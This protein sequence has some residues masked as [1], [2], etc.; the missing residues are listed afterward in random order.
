MR[1]W[2]DADGRYT[3]NGYTSW[4]HKLNGSIQSLFSPSRSASQ[5][6]I[7]CLDV[8]SPPYDISIVWPTPSVKDGSLPR[9]RNL[10]IVREFSTEPLQSTVINLLNHVQYFRINW[11][12]LYGNS[13]CSLR[14]DFF[15]VKSRQEQTHVMPSS[16]YHY[17]KALME[18]QVFQGVLSLLVSK[19]RN[20]IRLK[21]D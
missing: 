16:C 15:K 19:F 18:I 7:T 4:Y 20:H 2:F 5:F 14:F 8:L 1:N 10:S 3:Q 13:K 12:T 11:A 17:I 9:W 6:W 21:C